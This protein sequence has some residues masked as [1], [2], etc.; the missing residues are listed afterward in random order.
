MNNRRLKSVKLMADLQPFTQSGFI[1]ASD[2]QGMVESWKTGD[3]TKLKA[4]I[5]DP[6]LPNSM[7]MLLNNLK[8]YF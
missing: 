5:Y 4:F 2:A 7:T 6:S 1:S 3:N 8:Q